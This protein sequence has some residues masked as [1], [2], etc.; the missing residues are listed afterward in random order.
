MT[1]GRIGLLLALLAVAA[2]AGA[3]VLLLRP[4]TPTEAGGPPLFVD[5]TA[6]AILRAYVNAVLTGASLEQ[7]T[8]E[9]AQLAL[10]RL[11]GV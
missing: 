4:P 10:G 7:E 8:R 1:R 6:P 11:E 3:G 5:E 9:D 2:V